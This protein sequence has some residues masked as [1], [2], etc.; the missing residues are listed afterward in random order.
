MQHLQHTLK[1]IALDDAGDSLSGLSAQL[2]AERVLLA[3]D[4]EPIG[5]FGGTSAGFKDFR[6]GLRHSRGGLGD[7]CFALERDRFTTQFGWSACAKSEVLAR[8]SAARPSTASA[9]RLV[10][11]H[12]Q[13]S[14]RPALIAAAMRSSC[15][16]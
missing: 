14:A 10:S 11:Q 12:D 4:G 15:G 8:N 3:R 7:G 6:R 1:L 9:S 16:T 13:E 5:E 2:E